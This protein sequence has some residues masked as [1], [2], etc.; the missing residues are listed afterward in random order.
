MPQMSNRKRQI[1]QATR[2]HASIDRALEHLKSLEEVADGKNPT[3]NDSMTSLVMMGLTWQNIVDKVK[4]A[5]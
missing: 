2:V 4:D 5:L 3:V 1:Y